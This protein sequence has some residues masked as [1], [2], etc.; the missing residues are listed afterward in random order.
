[1]LDFEVIILP[2]VEEKE[3]LVLTYVPRWHHNVV[4]V[5]SLKGAAVHHTSRQYCTLR[6]HTLCPIYDTIEL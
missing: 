6:Q 3:L 1:M 4:S 2:P 5:L